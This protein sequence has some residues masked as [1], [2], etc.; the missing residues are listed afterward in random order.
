M[1]EEASGV[2]GPRANVTVRAWV[3]MGEAVYD[4]WASVWSRWSPGP[5]CL[6]EG[7]NASARGARMAVQGHAQEGKA[8]EEM[9]TRRACAAGVQARRWGGELGQMANIGPAQESLIFLSFLFSIQFPNFNS[10]LHLR[11]KFRFYCTNK[12]TNMKFT[13]LFI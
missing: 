2:L 10:N 7:G 12:N 3:E 13:N 4:G 9:L 1:V 11:F 6:H 8:C 5:M